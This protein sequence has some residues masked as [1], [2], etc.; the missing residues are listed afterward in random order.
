MEASL[1]LGRYLAEHRHTPFE[2]GIMDCCLFATRWIDYSQDKNTTDK[3]SGTYTT[4]EELQ[5]AFKNAKVKQYLVDNGYQQ[6]DCKKTEALNGD[7][8]LVDEL[9]HGSAWLVLNNKIHT[10]T[11]RG[12]IRVTI[13][14]LQQPYTIWR[15]IK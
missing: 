13:G 8:L 7:I 15:F 1:K 2:L 14:R 5:D 10:M 4:T 6:V 11:P 9:D 3:Y 12:L